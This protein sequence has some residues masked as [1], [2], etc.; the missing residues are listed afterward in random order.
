SSTS[1]ASRRRRPE[2]SRWWTSSTRCSYPASANVA[3]KRPEMLLDMHERDRSRPLGTADDVE[4]EPGVGLEPER[5]D[6]DAP[7]WA[8]DQARGVEQMRPHRRNADQDA[9]AAALYGHDPH[10][11]DDVGQIQQQEIGSALGTHIRVLVPNERGHGASEPREQAAYDGQ[12][13]AAPGRI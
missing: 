4:I 10:A 13:G 6:A 2:A 3:D 11:V 12:R 7:C 1:R 5:H 9:G 8:R